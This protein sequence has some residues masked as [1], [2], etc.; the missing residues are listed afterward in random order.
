MAELRAI[1]IASSALPEIAQVVDFAKQHPDPDGERTRVITALEEHWRRRR[2]VTDAACSSIGAPSGSTEVDH[3]KAGRVRRAK[4]I[5]LWYAHQGTT[6]WLVTAG[7]DVSTR[8]H[9]LGQG[10]DQD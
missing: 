1:A 3:G 9:I 7:G 5:N 6:V 2:C 4:G 8:P 10:L